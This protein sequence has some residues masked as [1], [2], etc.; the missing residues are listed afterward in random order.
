MKKTIITFSVVVILLG[1]GIWW[2]NASYKKENNQQAQTNTNISNYQANRS[3][4]NTNIETKTNTNA[5]IVTKEEVEIANF[6]TKI[7]NK[8]EDRSDLFRF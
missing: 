3:G 2:W 7:Y 5:D 6:T 4:T 1:A 8:D